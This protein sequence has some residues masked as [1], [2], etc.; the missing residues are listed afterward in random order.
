MTGVWVVTVDGNLI[1]AIEPSTSDEV[2][3]G[4]RLEVGTGLANNFREKGCIDGRYVFSGAHDAQAFA[5][6][7]LE[8]VKALLEQRLRAVK[9]LPI[10]SSYRPA[11]RPRG[12]ADLP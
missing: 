7:C 11:T 5:T 10:G 2:V 9:D 12:A 8:F 4:S 1:S 3:P 6:L